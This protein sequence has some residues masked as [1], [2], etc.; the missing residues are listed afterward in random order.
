[1]WDSVEW[2]SAVG[3]TAGPT[4]A[5][6]CS[7]AGDELAAGGVTAFALRSAGARAALRVSGL[8]SAATRFACETRAAAGG[9]GGGA[10]RVLQSVQFDVPLAEAAGGDGRGGGAVL[11]AGATLSLAWEIG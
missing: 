7:W 10:T 5:R 11:E 9:G 8:P 2:D 6:A 3:P 4:V 1:M